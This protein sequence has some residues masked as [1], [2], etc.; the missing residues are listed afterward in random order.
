MNSIHIKNARV[1][2][3]KNISVEIE[4]EKLV[5]ITGVSGSGKSSLAFDTLYAEGQRRYVESLSSYARQFLERMDKPEVDAIEGI[6]PAMAIQQ[7]V[8]TSNPRSTVGTVTEVYDY[9]KLLFARLGKTYSPVS[10]KLVTRDAIRDVVD[11]ILSNETG[12][13]ILILTKIFVR[14]KGYRAELSINLQKGFTRIWREGEILSIEDLLEEENLEEEESLFLLIDRT[15]LQSENQEEMSSRIADSVQTA[16]QEGLGNCWVEINGGPIVHFSEKFE[17]DGISFEVPSV[18]LFSFNNPYGACPV[19]EGFGRVLGIDEDLVIPDKSLS[20]YEGAVAPW[21][22]EV[23]RQ[24]LNEFVEASEAVD[25][26]IHRPY[27][28]LTEQEREQLWSGIPGALGISAFFSF[29]ESKT[30]KIQYRVMLARYR[31][32]TTCSSCKGSRIRKDALYVKVGGYDIA[33][34]L[35]MELKDLLPTVEQLDLEDRDQQIGHRI[36]RELRDRLTYLNDVGLGYLTLNRKINT[37]SGGEMQRIRLAT[38]L[39][40]GLV[41]SM[42]ILDEPSIG[43]H[44][45]DTDRLITILEML[46]EQGNTV[47]VVEHDEG[48]M[49]QA[50]QLIDLGPGAGELGGEVVF[51]GTYSELLKTETLTGSYLKGTKEIPLPQAR[52]K[53]SSEIRLQ[54]ASMHNLKGVDVQ[55][56]LNALT[57]V[58]GVSGSGKSTL[59]QKIIYPILKN[60][61]GDKRDMRGFIKELEGDLSLIQGVE[62]VDQS[63]VG[64]SARSN[65]ATYVKAYDHI[66]DLFSKQKQAKLKGLKPGHFSFNVDGGRCDECQGEGFVTVEMQFLPDVKLKCEVCQGKRFKRH[67]LDIQYKK[68]NIDDILNM[69]IAEAMEFFKDQKKIYNKFYLLDRVGLGYL[70]VGQSTSTLSGGEAQRMK[71]AFFLSQSTQNKG[72]VYIFDE[73]TTGLHFED[74]QKLMIALNDLIEEGN[75][76][77]VIEHNLDVIKCADWIIDIGPEGGKEGG[78]IVFQGRPEDLVE[79]PV[80]YTA[81]YL[82]EKLNGV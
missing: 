80:S 43:L 72:V 32:Y 75:T 55:I 27:Y 46:R 8:S 63:P 26:P 54:G 66:R 50:D 49:R 23:M 40:S 18:N 31:G 1:N 34:F 16:Y 64:R 21:R 12:S 47:I 73:P 30:H 59:V 17:A 79:N 15:K 78:T 5:V 36:I 82:K 2:N 60:Y 14:S 24:Y 44:P 57:V 67:I 37:L 20:L 19:C 45:R 11:Y 39:G 77:I 38:S 51:N 53:F 9:L 58:T 70:R 4:R 74:I 22:G 69:T 61:K 52:R 62:L 3:L 13:R 56:P 48:I 65:P 42:Y 33:Q 7:K 68:K 25:F 10:G 81:K 71:L 28:D 35:F 6:A 29:L 76:I 41:G